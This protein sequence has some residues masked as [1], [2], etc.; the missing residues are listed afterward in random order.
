[1]TT[2]TT[3]TLDEKYAQFDDH[4]SPHIVAELNGQHVK[5]A[6]VKGEFIWHRH[7]NEDELFMVLKGTLY[8]DFREGGTRTIGPGQLLVVP[9]GMDHRPYTKG[10]EEVHILM[11]EPA[12]TLN[13]GN[14]TTEHTKT[15]L[16]RI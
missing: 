8:I 6:K 16:P 4:W 3:I 1:M 15:D 5:I 10:R 9:A 13:T 2:P 7:E 12:G 11:M 14:V